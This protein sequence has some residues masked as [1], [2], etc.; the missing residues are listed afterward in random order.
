MNSVT[1]PVVMADPENSI[2]FRN[3]ITPLALIIAGLLA[4]SID[5]SVATV[6][7]E[8]R[9]PKEIDRPL[10]ELLEIC[11]AF[12]HGFGAT[13]I[14]IGVAV[15]A[16][17]KRRCIPWLFA[18]SLGAGLTAN[19]LKLLVRRARP[20]SFDLTS[21]SVWDTFIRTNSDSGGMQS[22][23]SAHTATAVGLAIM[24][25]TLFPRGRWYFSLLAVLAGMQ[26]IASS[27]H[28]PSDVCAGAVVGWLVGTVC[29]WMMSNSQP[30]QTEDVSLQRASRRL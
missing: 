6:F 28:F 30:P 12:S 7:K 2:G 23:P 26:R 8:E 10:K 15:L 27:A 25:A 14:I 9:L 3:W 22:F 16:P 21:G 5:V 17:A 20:R 19:S 11:E 24:L 29:A 18:G 1:T 4:L 13:L